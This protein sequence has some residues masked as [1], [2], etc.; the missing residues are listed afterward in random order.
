MLRGLVAPAFA[1]EMLGVFRAMGAAQGQA[2]A[3]VRQGADL[4]QE[5]V[6]APALYSCTPTGMQG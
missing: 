1:A 6:P 2:Y 4:A 3:T 5:V